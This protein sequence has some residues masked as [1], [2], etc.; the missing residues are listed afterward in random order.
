MEI[1]TVQKDKDSGEVSA[2]LT[3]TF[4]E[5]ENRWLLHKTTEISTGIQCVQKRTIFRG[6]Q[7]YTNGQ[8]KQRLK[9]AAH[10]Y[11]HPE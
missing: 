1:N 2:A 7:S 6:A 9:L 5:K 3:L 8:T 4:I 11:R 10:C